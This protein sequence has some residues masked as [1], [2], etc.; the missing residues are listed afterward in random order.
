MVEQMTV[1][2]REEKCRVIAE[3]IEPMPKSAPCR[4]GAMSDGGVWVGIN[5][6]FPSG[7]LGADFFTSEAAGAQIR[8]KLR[9]LYEVVIIEIYAA[10]VDHKW[11]AIVKIK[12]NHYGLRPEDEMIGSFDTDNELEAI[13]EAAY[14]VAMKEKEK[15][16]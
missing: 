7:W 16:K 10:E 1:P 2:T 15:A 5:T 11:P 8:K 14:L 6:G 9:E 3:W 12:L 4:V 13:A